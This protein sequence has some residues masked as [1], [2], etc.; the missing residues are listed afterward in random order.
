M[1]Q[2]NKP[3]TYFNSVLYTGNGGTNN[4]TGVEFQP[5][6]VW[7]KNRNS[8]NEHCVTDVVRGATKYLHTNLTQAETTAANSLTSFDSDGF[9]LGSNANFNTNT[10]TYVA[11]NWLADNTSGSSNTDGSITSTVSSNTTSGFSIVTYTGTGVSET[12]GHGLGAVPNVIIVKG[13]SGTSAV[14]GWYTYHSSV[15]NTKFV[16]LNNTG[17]A[18]TFST[19][20]DNTTPTTTT[21]STTYLSKASTNYVAYF[22]AEKKGFSKFGGYTGNGSTD[23]TF[24]YTGFKPAFVIIKR[25][26]ASIHNWIMVDNKRNIFNTVGKALFPNSNGAEYDYSTIFDFVSNG[27]KLRANDAWNN[28]SGGTYIYMAFAENPLVGT[29]NIP[30]TAR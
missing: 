29:N 13:S 1:A 15:G 8:T 16:E 7:I 23:G 22:F 9:S 4:I 2:I 18:T 19:M 20:W 21:F 3:N 5:D 14:D 25:T 24:V 10:N 28:A 27:F 30:A 11:W 26:D 17:G 12:I 6:L